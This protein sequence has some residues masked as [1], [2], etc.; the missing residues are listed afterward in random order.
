VTEC[1]AL[2]AGHRLRLPMRNDL[3]RVVTG[4]VP[5]TV[6]LFASAERMRR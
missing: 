4:Q 3:K 1:D 2:E 5:S 6:A